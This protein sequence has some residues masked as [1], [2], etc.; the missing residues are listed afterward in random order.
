M[1]TSIGNSSPLHVDLGRG[2]DFCNLTD[3][4]LGIDKIH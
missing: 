4:F 3:L 1:M 2:F